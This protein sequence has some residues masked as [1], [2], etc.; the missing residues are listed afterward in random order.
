[1]ALLEDVLNGWSG[2]TFIGLGAIVALPL[3]L[4]LVRAV[5]RPVA[6]L[7][8]QGGLVVAEMLQEFTAQGGEQASDLVVEAQVEYTI[9][10]NG[11]T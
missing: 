3:F 10:G 9:N 8:I 4:P 6:K 11:A 5:V 7:A 2:S 1:M